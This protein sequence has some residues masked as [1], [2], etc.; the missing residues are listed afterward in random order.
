MQKVSEPEKE[1]S[2]AQI[3]GKITHSAILE[4]DFSGFV[5]KPDGMNFTTKEGKAW[6]ASQTKQ[7]INQEYASNIASMATSVRNHPLA[8]RILFTEKGHNEVSCW[9]RHITTELILKGRADR[10]T[11]DNQGLT[12]VVDL[13]TCGYGEASPQ[14]FS[15]AIF[16]WKYHSQAAWYMD[17]FGASFFVFVVVE[18]EAPWAVAC[19]N[20]DSKSIQIGRE[21]NEHRLGTIKA[22]QM[23]GVWPAY[24]EALN[25][26]NIPEWA[27]RGIK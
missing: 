21:L 25:Q 7:I 19:Y 18:K 10:I 11:T 16:N 8:S 3:I 22:C 20:L 13:K 5:V 26:I 27:Q 17:L 15:K 12:T 9:S 4:T 2:E 24:S 14:L 6:R 1:A 23:T